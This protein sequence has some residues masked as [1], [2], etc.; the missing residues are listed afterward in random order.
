MAIPD[1]RLP[2]QYALNFPKRLE[3]NAYSINFNRLKKLTFHKPDLKK[4]PCLC[5]AYEASREGGT[6]PAV[7]NAANEEAV[8]MYLKGRLKFTSIPKVIEKA[9]RSH[10][11]IKRYNL[12]DTIYA[13]GW[14]REEVKRIAGRGV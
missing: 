10:T 13:D 11:S 9:L 8:W 14:A 6:S 5:L 4:F 7:L 3:T 1:M 12:K 2:I